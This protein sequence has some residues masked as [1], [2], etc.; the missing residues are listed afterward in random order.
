MQGGRQ[1][2][3]AQHLLRWLLCL[4]TKVKGAA[5]PE[6]PDGRV[7]PCKWGFGVTYAPQSG[8]LMLVTGSLGPG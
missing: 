2:K 8:E 3:Y 4:A 1:P 5:D 7:A 6:F